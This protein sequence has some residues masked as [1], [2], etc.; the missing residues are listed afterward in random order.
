M[1]GVL[2]KVLQQICYHYS[3]AASRVLIKHYLAERGRAI[4][5]QIR[6]TLKKKEQVL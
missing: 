2:V 5:N 4:C 1:V 3:G 6:R